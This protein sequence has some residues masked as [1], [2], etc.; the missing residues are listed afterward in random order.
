[1]LL[2]FFI[3]IIYFH[4]K[5]CAKCRI[6][7]KGSE[8]PFFICW[9]ILPDLTRCP[10]TQGAFGKPLRG[11]A[12]FQKRNRRWHTRNQ[13]LLVLTTGSTRIMPGLVPEEVYV[14]QQFVAWGASRFPFPSRFAEDGSFDYAQGD[15]RKFTTLPVRGGLDG[16]QNTAALFADRIQSQFHQLWL[17]GGFD[18]IE[19]T[20]GIA[21]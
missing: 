1:M 2:C 20:D 18:H 14:C 10:A 13:G 6:I 7:K 5:G 4:R 12:P 3:K 19:T 9:Y 11:K 21:I 16:R 8:D 17:E 15:N